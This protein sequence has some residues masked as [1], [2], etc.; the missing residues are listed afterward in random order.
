MVRQFHPSVGGL[1]EVVLRL[2]SALAGLGMGSSVVTLDRIKQDGLGRVPARD[3]VA[4]IPVTRIP[5]GGSFRYPIAPSVLTHLTGADLVH[6]HGIDFFF[7]FLAATRA[8]HRRR[9]VAS[10]HGGFFHTAFAHRLKQVYFQTVTRAAAA[11][12]EVICASSRSDHALFERISPGNT[13]LVE[14]GVDV[15]KWRGLASRSPARTMVAVGRF[16]SNKQLPKLF[17]LLAALRARDPA[18]VLTIAGSPWD[19][20]PA[21]L[22]G[23]AEALGLSDAVQVVASPSDAA[24]AATI[25]RSTYVVSGSRHEGFGLGVVEGMSAGL[26]PLLNRIPA[27][28]A[29]AAGSDV[30][31]FVDIDAPDEAARLIEAHHAKVAASGHDLRQACI[32]ASARYGWGEAAKRF[33]ERYAATLGR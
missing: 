13:A 22:V 25:G 8:V 18:W 12:Y 28:E 30:A 1:E 11:R 6:V 31:C 5:F 20:S 2:C 10:T 17:P 19:V 26:V 29:I 14:N 24:L 4:G 33:A 3:T 21:D 9:L 23:Q 16:S 7:D 32:D 15:E 27:F